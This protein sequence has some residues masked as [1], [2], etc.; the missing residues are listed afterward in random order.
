MVKVINGILF[1]LCV[2]CFNLNSIAQSMYDFNDLDKIIIDSMQ[3]HQFSSMSI[4]IIKGNKVIYTKGYGYADLKSKIPTTDETVYQIGSLTKTFTGNLLSHFILDGKMKLDDSL[5]L[6][7]PKTVRF[8]KDS[9]G[10]I[11][12]IKDLATH[13]SGIPRYP[14]NL[15]RIDGEPILSYPKAKMHEAITTTQ[16]EFNIGRRYNYSNFAYGILG[17]AME[18]TTGKTYNQLLEQYIF[19]PLKMLHTSAELDQKVKS[20]LATA[21]YDDN[22][23]VETK[24][25]KMESLTAHGGIFSNVKDLCKFILYFR[26]T[27]QASVKLQ[28]TAHF[29]ISKRTDYGLGCFMTTYTEPNFDRVVYHGGDLDSYSSNFIFYPD[30]DFAYII[31]SSGAGGQALGRLF[32]VIETELNKKLG[33]MEKWAPIVKASDDSISIQR[34]MIDY[35]EGFYDGDSSKI[36]RAVSPTVVKYGYWKE[37]NASGYMGE[38]M[39]YKEMVQ[40]AVNESKNITKAKWGSREKVEIYDVQDQTAS[41]K[42]TAWWGTDFILLEKVK[43]K[44]MIRMVLWQGPLKT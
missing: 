38:A 35:I 40:Y 28:R 7:F 19:S 21:Y 3:V 4:G 36:I 10:R 6:Y 30:K 29:K 13:S 18:N 23:S 8:P 16:L 11:L 43:D 42:I 20:K 44:W 1:T 33:S 14:V 25:W 37:S 32:N 41:G 22:P 26:D 9:T 31:L 15:D 34:A 24:P 17:T 27:T 2:I 12:T 5:S 39:S